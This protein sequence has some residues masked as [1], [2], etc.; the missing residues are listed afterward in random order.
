MQQ[1]FFFINLLYF[2]KPFL[3]YNDNNNICTFIV[4]IK[5]TVCKILKHFEYYKTDL[6]V[7]I[8]SVEQGT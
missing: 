2:L 3:Q 4:S 6:Q 5:Y 8:I 7:F 1:C